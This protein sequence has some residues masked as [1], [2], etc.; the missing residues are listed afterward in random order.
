MIF[1]TLKFEQLTTKKNTIRNAKKTSDL[2]FK[3][4][5]KSNKAHIAK[6]LL[7]RSWLVR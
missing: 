7:A 6:C 4:F 3:N 5:K 1:A 2:I